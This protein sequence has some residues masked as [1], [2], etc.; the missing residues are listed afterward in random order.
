MADSAGPDERHLDGYDPYDLLDAEA[1]RIESWLGGFADDDPVWQ[2]PSRCADWNVR[3]V[4][5]HLAAVEEYHHACLDGRVS[6]FIEAGLAQGFTSLDEFN[7][8]GVDERAGTPPSALL[9]EWSAGDAETRRRL[10]ERDGGEIDSTVGAYPLRWQA[11]HVAVELAVHADDIALPVTPDEAADR[12]AWRTAFS[13]FALT[14]KDGSATVEDADGGG[15]HVVIGDAD[16]V[17]DDLSLVAALDGR[18]GDD[19]DPAVRAALVG[20]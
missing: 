16:L 15:T 3:E 9:A 11:F 14:E 5:A 19:A 10:R 12:L 2:Q 8:A 20:H 7:Q 6:A 1:A 13:R 4:L 17:V 18:L